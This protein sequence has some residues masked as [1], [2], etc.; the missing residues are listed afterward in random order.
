MKNNKPLNSEKLGQT[1]IE[2]MTGKVLY[3]ELKKLKPY[4][5]LY[6][7]QMIRQQGRSPNYIKSLLRKINYDITGNQA[8]GDMAAAQWELIYKYLIAG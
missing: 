4:S 7:E 1:E 6:I 5:T 8:L 3:D 2:L